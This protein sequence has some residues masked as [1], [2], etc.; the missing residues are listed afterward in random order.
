MIPN[1]TTGYEPNAQP[2]REMSA[3]QLLDWYLEQHELQQQRNAQPC[4]VPPT[5]STSAL[6]V[7]APRALTQALAPMS[8]DLALPPLAPQAL[9]QT[10]APM[11]STLVSPTTAPKTLM[12]AFAQQ[13]VPMVPSPVTSLIPSHFGLQCHVIHCYNQRNWLHQLMLSCSHH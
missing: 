4:D 2:H 3:D 7:P 8:S 12:Q 6:P 11:S 13:A 10:F 9:T 5:S 1:T